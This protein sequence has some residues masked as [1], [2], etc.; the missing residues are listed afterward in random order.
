MFYYNKNLQDERPACIEITVYVMMTSPQLGNMADI[1]GFV[2]T[3][4]S[5]ITN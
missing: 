5:A 1:S 3:A 2:S 4:K